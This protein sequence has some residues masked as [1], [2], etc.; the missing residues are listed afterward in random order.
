MGEQAGL[1]QEVYGNS[2]YGAWLVP[3]TLS[4]DL[5]VSFY[6]C[7]LGVRLHTYNLGTG[8][9]MLGMRGGVS[10]RSQVTP[11]LDQ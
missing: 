7:D 10:R 6:T 2:C 4:C 1:D 5:G 8:L 11:S 9:H 3:E